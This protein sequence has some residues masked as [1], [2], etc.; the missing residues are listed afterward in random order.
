MGPNWNFRP[1]GN[2]EYVSVWWRYRRKRSHNHSKWNQ[3]REY[4]FFGDPKRKIRL[5][6]KR[7][8]SGIFKREKSY[9]DVLGTMYNLFQDRDLFREKFGKVMLLV[10]QFEVFQ[11]PTDSSGQVFPQL[12]AVGPCKHFTRSSVSLIVSKSLSGTNLP[13]SLSSWLKLLLASFLSG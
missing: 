4:H 2:I 6:I 1:N 7:T 12:G 13:C 9:I 8:P 3:A 5:H 11:C 10:S